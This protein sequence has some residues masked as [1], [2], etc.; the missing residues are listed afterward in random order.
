MLPKRI[1]SQIYMKKSMGF[2]V[3][4]LVLSQ[5]SVTT[6]SALEIVVTP[7]GKT[8]LYQDGVLGDST[9]ANHEPN[10]LPQQTISPS[11]E[12]L[13]RLKNSGDKHPV[14]MVDKREPTRTEPKALEAERMRLLMS[15]KPNPKDASKSA[16][17]GDKKELIKDVRS[18]EARQALEGRAQ[19][20]E[21]KIELRRATAASVSALELKSRQDK[22]VVQGPREVIIDPETNEVGI[23]LPNG[24]IKTLN[25]LP[26]QAQ[27][28][29]SEIVQNNENLELTTLE[30]GRVVYTTTVPKVYRFLGLFRREIPTKVTMDD[31][32]GEVTQEKEQKPGIARFLN[33]LSF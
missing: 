10:K 20:T 29:I 25:H 1:Y 26:D 30:D 9:E 22:A 2:L 11:Q 27:A 32:T 28:R 16:A 5:L 13:I 6:V 24:E 7:T 21:E 8:L 31:G 12:K 4:V 33:L 19:R 23:V 17:G 18:L 14:E 15:A 3:A